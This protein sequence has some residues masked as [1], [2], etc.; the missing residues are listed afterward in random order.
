M[1]FQ[2]TALLALAS[3]SLWPSTL[4]EQTWPN[5][6]IDRLEWLLY[7]QLGGFSSPGIAFFVK[8]CV[9][10]GNEAQGINFGAEWLRNAYHDM[11]TA[12][13]MAGTGGLDASIIFELDR[14]ENVGN[15]FLETQSSFSGFVTTRSSMADLFALGA[16]F[17][18]GACSNGTMI[19]P[20]RAGRVDAREAG[21][22]GVPQPQEDI[23]TH[24]AAFARQGFNATEM[25]ELVACGHTIGGVHGVDFPEIAPFVPD[26]DPDN[27]H[28]V[29]FDKSPRFFENKVATEFIS[30]TT[31]NPLV[32]GVNVTTQS[33][34]CIFNL[35]SGVTM[36]KLA[37]SNDYFISRCSILLER[38]LNTVPQNVVL[39]EPINFYPV[40]P[41][42]TCTDINING[43]ITFSGVIR[44]A[45]SLLTSPNTQVRLYFVPRNG[46]DCSDATPCSV[47]NG[48]GGKFGHAT[49]VYNK[50]SATFSFFEYSL[51]V[52]VEQGASSFMVEIIGGDTGASVTY[53]N[54]GNG[55]PIEQGLQ[56]Q[57]QLSTHNSFLII[58]PNNTIINKQQ[59]NL[60]VAVFN[61]EQFTNITAIFYEPKIPG[62]NIGGWNPK[63]VELALSQRVEGTNFTYYTTSYTYISD[64]IAAHPFDIRATGSGINIATEFI[65]WINFPLKAT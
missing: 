16:T 24:T 53:N 44:V 20:L 57:Y 3:V 34:E 26:D 50:C 48:I 46:S 51:V 31:Q 49:C 43:T 45:D 59:L 21:P 1:V 2:Q 30:N 27:E 36:R 42:F 5:A 14:E 58:G 60:T 55:F 40:K 38:M 54:N 4:G 23:T 12:D 63:P 41:R 11:S 10:I 17:A 13:I 35:D 19:I 15:A 64:G 39:T 52:P 32:S 25:I 28:T 37:E 33:D 29:T 18:I 22:P 7:E 6:R 56:P 61:A 62:K 47:A 8:D 65:E 9:G